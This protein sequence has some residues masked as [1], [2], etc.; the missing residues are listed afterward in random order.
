MRSAS[1]R[2]SSLKKAAMSATEAVATS[3]APP[4]VRSTKAGRAGGSAPGKSGCDELATAADADTLAGAEAYC[5]L[6]GTAAS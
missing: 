2:C 6:E 1:T 3:E 4:E 5:L